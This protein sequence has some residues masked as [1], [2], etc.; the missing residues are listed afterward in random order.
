MSD[1]RHAK[2]G[3][4]AYYLPGHGDKKKPKQ[5]DNV[6]EVGKM[7]QYQKM[8]NRQVTYICAACANH[9]ELKASDVVRC[10]ECGHRI[11]YKKRT[12]TGM[13]Y[14]AR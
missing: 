3:F 14:E 12:L 8:Y 6:L 13:M 1:P 5:V 4:S 2:M 7:Q 11:L 9:V 10:R